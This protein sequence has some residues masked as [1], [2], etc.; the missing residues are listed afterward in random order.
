[1]KTIIIILFTAIQAIAQVDTIIKNEVYESYFS[2]KD[3]NPLYVKYKLYQGG[4]DCNRSQFH[5]TTDNLPNSATSV[6]YAHSGY[7]EGHL[8]NA[9]DFAYDCQKEAK[10]FRFYNCIP[11]T[12]NLNRGIWKHYETEIRKLSQ[13]DSLLILCG[14]I[15]PDT[16]TGQLHIPHHCWKLVKSLTTNQTVYCLWF[17]NKMA[18]NEV[19]SI[20]L[21]E[22]IERLSYSIDY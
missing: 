9:E 15:Y 18:N 20:T 1:M 4:G 6:D 14:A 10:T 5:F 8:C 21:V 22:L 16:V 2:Y 13:T 12:P 7:D 17:T 11:Q 19:Q 3:R